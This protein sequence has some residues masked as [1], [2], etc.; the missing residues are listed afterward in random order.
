MLLAIFPRCRV[1]KSVKAVRESWRYLLRPRSGC[2][3]LWSTCVSVCLSVRED[4]S[5]ITR[6][7]FNKFLC[8]LPM[9]VARSS[10]VRVTKSHAKGAILGFLPPWQCIVQHGIW[11][12]YKNGR[13]DRDAVSAVEWAWPE[14]QCV[15][16]V[17]IPE[18]VGAVL[19]KNALSANKPNTPNNCELD[20]SMQ[21]HTTGADSW[22]QALD[23]S[24][25]G[26]EVEAGIA[27]RGRSLITIALLTWLL[28][29][30]HTWK[31]VTTVP[32][33]MQNSRIWSKLRC[34]V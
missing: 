23:E 22:L 27:H 15:T 17:T 14:D 2:Q 34:F 25:I 7:I 28:I 3:V 4:I 10:F 13:T 8:M 11:D 24:I 19:G 18:R 6:A 32:Y 29:C 33:E 20:W 16:W 26:R 30:P 5:G 12:P 21:R 9:A 31:N 1:P